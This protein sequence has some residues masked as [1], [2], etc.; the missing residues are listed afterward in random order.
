MNANLLEYGKRTEV[1]SHS[2]HS[3]HPN[4]EAGLGGDMLVDFGEGTLFTEPIHFSEPHL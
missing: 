3:H 2:G 4:L 1:D